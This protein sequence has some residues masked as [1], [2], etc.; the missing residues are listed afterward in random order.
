MDENRAR[1]VVEALRSH[2]VDA[3]LKKAGVYQFGIAVSLPDGVG[4]RLE[5]GHQ[6]PD[7]GVLA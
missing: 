2:G 7:A 3:S 4:V 1:R 6:E 5:V